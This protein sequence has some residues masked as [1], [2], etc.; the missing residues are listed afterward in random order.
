MSIHICC[1]NQSRDLIGNY[2][3]L[4]MKGIQDKAIHLCWMLLYISTLAIHCFALMPVQDYKIFVGFTDL[5]WWF[6]R[7]LSIYLDKFSADRSMNFVCLMLIYSLMPPA[8]S[9]PDRPVNKD[10]TCEY[11]LTN[12]LIS[13]K[14]YNRIKSEKIDINLLHI[15]LSR[16]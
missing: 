10:N 13:N 8:C 3:V 4:I 5:Y 14:N 7:K 11:K 1:L 12:Y 2:V 9:I 16:I 15:V 6:G